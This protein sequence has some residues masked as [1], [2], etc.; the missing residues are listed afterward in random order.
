[1]APSD[2]HN[3]ETSSR[4]PTRKLSTECPD[5]EDEAPSRQCV[6]TSLWRILELNELGSSVRKESSSSE[7]KEEAEVVKEVEREELCRRAGP[8]NGTGITQ[9]GVS[10]APGCSNGLLQ[11]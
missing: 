9:T 3:L 5:L 6:V 7:M 8:A 11:K 10:K 4:R 1:M 2:C